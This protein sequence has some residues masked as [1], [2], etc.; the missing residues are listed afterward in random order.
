[1][2]INIKGTI[3]IVKDTVKVYDL[4]EIVKNFLNLRTLCNFYS[5]ERV[6]YLLDTTP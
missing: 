5:P 6:G 1:M 4:E 2:K 3:E